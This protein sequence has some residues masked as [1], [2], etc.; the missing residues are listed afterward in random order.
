[1]PISRS[2]KHITQETLF[3]FPEPEGTETIARVISTRGSNQLEIEYPNGEKVLCLLPSKFI[4]KIWVKRGDFLIVDPVAGN[5]TTDCKILA[6]VRNILYPDQIKHLRQKQLWPSE[7]EPKQ[8][9][10]EDDIIS[11]DEE[12][13]EEE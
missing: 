12:E 13:E 5:K 11:D 10:K 7:F 4:K 9:Q 1:M 6:T 8:Q 3:A 2:R